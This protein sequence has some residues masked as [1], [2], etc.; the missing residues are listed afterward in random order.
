MELDGTNLETEIYRVQ[1]IV[2]QLLFKI[3][4]QLFSGTSPIFFKGF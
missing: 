3:V 2:V 1:I 4:V